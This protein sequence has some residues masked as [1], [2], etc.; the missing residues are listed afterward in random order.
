MNA[1]K[2]LLAVLT[3]AAVG[4]T[5]GILFAPNK[6]SKTRKIILMK[7]EKSL[8]ALEDKFNEFI[9]NVI[10]TFDSMNRETSRIVNHSKI[11]AEDALAE[12]VHASQGKK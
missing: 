10:E 4:A 1:G 2:V 11:E 9:G 7:K 5:L 3:G 6:G 12:V 8:N